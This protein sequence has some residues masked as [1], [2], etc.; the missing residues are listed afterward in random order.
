VSAVSG[1]PWFD[2]DIISAPF[3][4]G[5]F[6]CLLIE[7]STPMRCEGNIPGVTSGLFLESG[8]GTSGLRSS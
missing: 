5:W 3:L 6:S 1:G 4:G 7:R 8:K 2:K